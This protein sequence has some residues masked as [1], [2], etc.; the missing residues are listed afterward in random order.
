MTTQHNHA[1][2][3]SKPFALICS[4]AV[5]STELN[6]DFTPSVSVVIGHYDSQEQAKQAR[7][8]IQHAALIAAWC[9]YSF[10]DEATPENM[11]VT[12]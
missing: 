10:L 7:Q 5:P 12:A 3:A 4:F 9:Y 2:V 11:G 6:P 8:A 1:P